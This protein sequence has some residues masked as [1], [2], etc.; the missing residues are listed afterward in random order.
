MML[1]LSAMFMTTSARPAHAEAMAIVSVYTFDSYGNIIA[2][3]DTVVTLG[4][5]YS[6]TTPG[7]AY[8]SDPAFIGTQ[9]MDS[10]GYNSGMTVQPVGVGS[11]MSGP[12][13]SYGQSSGGA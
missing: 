8:G 11:D 10:G 5:G 12:D 9:V 2:E 4:G 13:A 7:P 1:L 6:A 3:T